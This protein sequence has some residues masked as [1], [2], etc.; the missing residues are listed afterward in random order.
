MQKYYVTTDNTA[1]F[2]SALSESEFA[3][4][5]MTYVVDG[6]LY[7]GE[8]TPFLSPHDF[9]SLL[10]QGKT[11]STS[12]I[13]VASAERFFSDILD[14]G[15]DILHIAFSSALSGSC[16]SY[17]QAAK[18][19]NS[20]YPD[21]RIIV[22]DSLCASIGEGL[23]TYYVLRKRASGA[24][25]EQCADYANQLKHHIGH[26]FTVDDMIHL[27]RG[28]R[29]S[30]P[31]AIAG[32]AMHIKPVLTV[33]KQGKLVPLH[34]AVGRRP[35]IRALV[36]NLVE[37]SGYDRDELFIIGHGDCPEEAEALRQLLTERLG[38][39]HI[40]ITDVGPVIGTH[41]GKGLL[42]ITGLCN[43][44]FPFSNQRE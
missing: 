31:A 30:M 14:K 6:I 42:V 15:Y 18:N 28:G 20:I 44:K 32:R 3:I 16:N 25:L 23:L 19:L 38:F 34:K 43:E 33:D 22:V 9:Y 39:V 21:K 7:D 35:A 10:A 8:N 40:I 5:P 4:V 26:Y 2:P 27:Y 41:C 11:S 12:M 17:I 1:D 36:N 24:S 29:V 37:H 13:S